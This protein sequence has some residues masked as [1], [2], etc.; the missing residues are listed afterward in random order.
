MIRKK[1]GGM[2]TIKELP[3]LEGVLDLFVRYCSPPQ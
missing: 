3:G 2:G 1:T